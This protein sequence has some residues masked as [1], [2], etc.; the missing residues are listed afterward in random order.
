MD[1]E[2][3][4]VSTIEETTKN[5]KVSKSKLKKIDL[6]RDMGSIEDLKDNFKDKKIKIGSLLQEL[7]T[8]ILALF[9]RDTKDLV[10][11]DCQSIATIRRNIQSCLD[12]VI[13]HLYPKG[14]KAE[15]MA[16]KKIDTTMLPENNSDLSW[17]HF[18]Q[19][20][21]EEAYSAMYQDKI[22]KTKTL[23]KSQRKIMLMIQA[24][25]V[26]EKEAIESYSEKENKKEY[27]KKN[28][29]NEIKYKTWMEI[30]LRNQETLLKNYAEKYGHVN[31]HLLDELDHMRRLSGKKELGSTLKN[32]LLTDKD[33]LEK[34]QQID[35]KTRKSP[36][37]LQNG[38]T[39]TSK[40]FKSSHLSIKDQ[41]HDGRKTK[42]KKNLNSLLEYHKVDPNEEEEEEYY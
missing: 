39:S 21:L 1:F 28:K 19:L 23:N 11:D 42:K 22:A 31:Q 35:F 18:T 13:D 29:N 30:S 2:E 24:K 15:I 38:S 32:K 16:K 33:P 37:L 7:A 17:F 9:F 8:A 26:L 20:A 27:K 10:R 14:K 3:D 6:M 25:K 41:S 40:K 12:S 36:L 4:D 34:I 5:S